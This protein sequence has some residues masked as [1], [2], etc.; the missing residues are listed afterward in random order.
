[1]D[2]D[3]QKACQGTL[4]LFAKVMWA[5]FI[6]LFLGAIVL[7]LSIGLGRAF[8]GGFCFLRWLKS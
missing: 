6:V 8:T 7:S 1:M 5:Q 2:F 4:R 3:F